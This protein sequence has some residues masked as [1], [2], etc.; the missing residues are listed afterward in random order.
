MFVLLKAFVIIT[1]EKGEKYN[2]YKFYFYSPNLFLSNL[3]INKMI[4]A[5]I[6]RENKINAV[7]SPGDAI[8]LFSN[9]LAAKLLAYYFESCTT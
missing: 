8:P 2:G 9:V 5:E 1:I 7:F 4:K 6:I 3:Y